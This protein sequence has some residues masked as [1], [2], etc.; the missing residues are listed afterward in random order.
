ML[1]PSL[2]VALSPLGHKSFPFS[3]RVTLTWAPSRLQRGP[4]TGRGAKPTGLV[5][6]RTRLSQFPKLSLIELPH[7]LHMFFYVRLQMPRPRLPVVGRVA[8]AACQKDKLI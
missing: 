8:D 2:L 6:G 5:S 7:I 3:R 4:Y 1:L